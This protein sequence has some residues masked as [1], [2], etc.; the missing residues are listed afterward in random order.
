MKRKAFC[1]VLVLFVITIFSLGCGGS[2]G[3]S[4]PASSNPAGSARV[5]GVVYDS[6]NNPVAN[7]SVRLVLA[8]NAVVN[9][10]IGNSNASLRF[11]TNAVQ[12]EFN[13]ATNNKGEYTFS[14]I[15]YGEY[16]LSAVTADKAQIVTHL[17]V[18]AAVVVPQDMRIM[19]FGTIKGNVKSDLA[20]KAGVIVY[21][22]GTSYSSATD[23]DGNFAINYIPARDEEYTLKVLTSGY[24]LSGDSTVIASVEKSEESSSL[25]WTK[26]LTLLAVASEKSYT[27]DC[28]V[29]GEGVSFGNLMV[30]AVNQED[31]TTFASKVEG[32]KCNLSITKV[33][34]YNVFTTLLGNGSNL[35]GDIQTITIRNLGSSEKINLSIGKSGTV[36]SNKGSISGKILVKNAT[37]SNKSKFTL[38]LYND[39]TGA[40]YKK[41][42]SN[43]SDFTFEK[44]CL[45]KKVKSYSP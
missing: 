35:A 39:E 13:T 1:L 34:T 42:L 26:D 28:S 40:E 10:L 19:P 23:S 15:P 37:E 31:G 11:A 17:A 21:V 9:S 4:N 12:T 27:L 16:T 24:E 20:Y 44:T 41:T 18:R 43:G 36:A 6:S 32:S 8:S 45:S 5:S 7:A 33:G 3:G 38:A 29:S 14:N 22:D 25:V 30:F 2:G